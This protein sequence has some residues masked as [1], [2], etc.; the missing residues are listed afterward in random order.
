M[1]K[2]KDKKLKNNEKVGRYKKKNIYIYIYNFSY[3]YLVGREEKW[4]NEN[5]ENKVCINLPLY[6]Y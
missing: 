3:L 4:R 2:W 6:S 1:E 5:F